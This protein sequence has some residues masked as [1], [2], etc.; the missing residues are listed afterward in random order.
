LKNSI[1][2]IIGTNIQKLRRAAGLKQ[3]EFAESLGCT[4]SNLSQIETGKTMATPVLIYN[5]ADILGCS[6]SDIMPEKIEKTKLIMSLNVLRDEAFAY[7]E[8][9]GFHNR[10]MNL[11]ERLMLVV[12]ELSEALE[13]DRNGKRSLD[14]LPDVF[15]CKILPENILPETEELNYYKSHVRGT[16]E[17]ELADAIIR[18]CDIAGIYG[19]NLDWHIAAKMAYNETRPY[20][21]GKKYG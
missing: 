2:K 12:S 10:K 6:V 9:Q 18:I 20:M 4:R 5:A 8:K 16:V 1:K 3:A 11:G 17:E 19:I 21:H 14:S 7:A 15:G 13:A